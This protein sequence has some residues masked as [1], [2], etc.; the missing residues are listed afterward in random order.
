[1]TNVKDLESREYDV[2]SVVEDKR[3]VRCKKEMWL[4]VVIGLVQILVP[5]AIIYSLNGNG[6]WFLGLPMWYA[7]ATVFYLCMSLICILVATTVIR[8]HKLDAVADDKE[9][10]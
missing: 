2:N 4:I 8:A 5:A 10:N 9:E 1:M 3:F 6:Q 7:V